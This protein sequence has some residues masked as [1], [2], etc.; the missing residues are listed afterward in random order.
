M[1]IKHLEEY[2]YKEHLIYRTIIVTNNDKENLIL[3][4]NLKAKDYNAIIINKI[5]SDI[6]Y[7]QIQCRIVIITYEMFKAFVE[8]LNTCDGGLLKSSYNLIAFTYSI[9]DKIRDDLIIFYLDKTN[10]ICDTIIYDKRYFYHKY[11]NNIV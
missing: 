2:I 9:L 6:D 4:K 7:N 10:N 8:H 5:E 3:E 1:F 11:L